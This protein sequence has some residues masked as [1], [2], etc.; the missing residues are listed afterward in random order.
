MGGPGKSRTAGPPRLAVVAN[1]FAMN[2]DRVRLRAIN[3]P[4]ATNSRFADCDGLLLDPRVY[5]NVPKFLYP[6]WFG[7]GQ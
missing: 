6:F 7:P 5:Q 3:E 2:C 1:G 4:P